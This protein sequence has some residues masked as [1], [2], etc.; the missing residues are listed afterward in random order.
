M[1]KISRNDPC[2]CGSGKKFKKCCL[3]KLIS[4]ATSKKEQEKALLQKERIEDD[5]LGKQLIQ[6]FEEKQNKQDWSKPLESLPEID[7]DLPLF[8]PFAIK[9]R[10]QL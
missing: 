10:I 3:D 5:V 7:S 2:P 8:E 1:N 6:D 9:G 4:I